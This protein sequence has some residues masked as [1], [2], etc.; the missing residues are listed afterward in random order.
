MF[1]IQR[2]KLNSKL[3]LQNINWQKSSFLYFR[4]E[5]AFY[6]LMSMFGWA[7]MP[8]Q[9]RLEDLDK[10]IPLTL[11][12]GSKSWVDH[13]PSDQIIKKRADSYVDF[14]VIK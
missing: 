11:V 4:G 7:K 5:S 9:E 10:S 8:M 14:H 1:K 12:Y 6:A 2:I 3:Q 13:C